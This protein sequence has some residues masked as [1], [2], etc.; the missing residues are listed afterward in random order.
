MIGLVE[1]PVAF[2]EKFG[3]EVKWLLTFLGLGLAF[4]ALSF[5]ELKSNVI[6]EV[7]IATAP[8]WLPFVTFLL[9]FEYWLLFV[10]KEFDIKQGRTTLEIK[11]PAHTDLQQ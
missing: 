2:L 5:L 7:M 9:F 11:L 10:Q 4:F 1:A 6:W 3:I 8:I